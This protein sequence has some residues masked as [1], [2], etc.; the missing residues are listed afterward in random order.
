MRWIAAV[1]AAVLTL[2]G[3]GLRPGVQREQ[4]RRPITSASAAP[5]V[6]RDRTPAPVPVEAPRAVAPTH[7]ATPSPQ[8]RQVARVPIASAT[9]STGPRVPTPPADARD[10]LW[11]RSFAALR[12]ADGGQAR[13]H[14][15]GIRILVHFWQEEGTGRVRVHSGCYGPL[16][17]LIEVTPT[18]LRVSSDGSGYSPGCRWEKVIAQDV[19]FRRVIDAG[20]R[21]RMTDGGRLVLTAGRRSITFAPHAWAAPWPADE[22][23]PGAELWGRSFASAE[24]TEDGV[25]RPPA[26]GAR[27]LINPHRRDGSGQLRYNG[28]CNTGGGWLRITDGRFVVGEREGTAMMCSASGRMEQE[29]WFEHLLD[30][31]PQWRWARDRTRLVLFTDRV[32]ILFEE[33]HW[34]PPWPADGRD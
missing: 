12:M 17:S 6:D 7:P 4:A 16:T 21:W 1:L 20:P 8:A 34:P 9:A 33:H 13:P 27:I 3:C 14:A 29:Q 30:A 22:P 11:G 31:D 24:I 2:A 19:W 5:D 23:A 15:H 26:D 28:G 10:A 25:V 32:R 18:R